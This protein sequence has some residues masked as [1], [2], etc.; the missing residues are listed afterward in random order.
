MPTAKPEVTITQSTFPGTGVI[1]SSGSLSFG[2]YNRF[3]VEDLTA[4]NGGDLTKFVFIPGM[5]GSQ[6]GIPRHDYTIRIYQGGTWGPNASDRNPGTLVHSQDLNNDLLDFETGEDNIIALTTSVKIDGTKELWIG[7]WCQATSP[8]GYPAM[9]DEG[10]RKA[11]LGDVMNYQG[12]TTL[13]DVIPSSTNW[14]MQGKVQIAIPTVNIYFNG[15]KVASE[16][17]GTCWQH[18]NITST[19]PYPWCYQ[20]EVNCVNGSTSPLSE[21]TDPS[22]YV[23]I[24]ENV[25]TGFSIAPNPATNS[26]AISAENNFHTIEVVSFLGQTVL[27]QPNAGNATTLDVSSLT[28]GVYF[29]RIISDNG[30]SVKKFVKQ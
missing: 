13:S 10:P 23:S 4:V 3:R 6:G 26:I 21:I 9:T 14:Y 2:V 16:R 15:T 28:N 17:E 11:G 30:T 7:Y 19:E 25:K 22:C 1:G 29:V 8:G 24:K 20:V 5:S 12:W 18:N 27:A